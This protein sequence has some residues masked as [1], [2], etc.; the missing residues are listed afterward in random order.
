MIAREAPALLRAQSRT[1]GH[2]WRGAF[3]AR[4][5]VEAK[6]ARV[7]ALHAD[8]EPD[9][10]RLA[11]VLALTLGWAWRALWARVPATGALCLLRVEGSS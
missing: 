6:A 5:E 11:D 9:Y 10:Q 3:F 4:E 1:P 8:G 2:G 7:G